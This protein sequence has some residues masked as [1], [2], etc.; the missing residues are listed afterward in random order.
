MKTASA[1][2]RLGK[3]QQRLLR[4]LLSHQDGTTIEELCDALSISHNAVR[5]HLSA[6][7]S[8]GFVA[9]GACL[10]SGGRPRAVYMLEAAGRNLFPRNYGLIA[11]GLLEHLYAKGGTTAVQEALSAIGARLG[12]DTVQQL[13]DTHNHAEITQRLATQL[14]VLGYETELITSK[15]GAAEIQA[16]NCV[17]QDLVHQHPDVCQLDLAFMHAATGHSIQ[18]T[19][20]MLHGQSS[21]RFRLGEKTKR[22]ES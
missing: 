3:T 18:R 6:L 7:M 5:Q 1:I 12:A 22:H 19:S 17:F 10:P 2:N 4:Y 13:D 14:D 16:W 9:R 20:C 8:E 21:C 11:Q 15:D